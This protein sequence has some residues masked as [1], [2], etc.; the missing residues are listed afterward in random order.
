MFPSIAAEKTH[1]LTPV[2]RSADLRWTLPNGPAT[3]PLPRAERLR[4]AEPEPVRA[5]L[6]P[7]RQLRPQP[8]ESVSQ[9]IARPTFT[10]IRTGKL[11]PARTPLS[12]EA[13]ATG[14]AT[15]YV[16]LPISLTPTVPD[17]GIDSATPSGAAALDTLADAPLV[18]ALASSPTAEAA[19][20]SPSGSLL[21][22]L[23]V[24]AYFFLRGGQ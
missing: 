5:P 1:P 10:A 4:T 2:A 16:P 12:G 13:V 11:L 18:D 24:L 17:V 20:S 21:L 23:A 9:E 15:P 3:R 6:Q 7:L 19:G 8:A 14:A 22:V